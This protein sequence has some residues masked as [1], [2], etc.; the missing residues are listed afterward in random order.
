MGLASGVSFDIWTSESAVSWGN[1]SSNKADAGGHSV[2]T[3]STACDD[4]RGGG[5]L[6]VEAGVVVPLERSKSTMY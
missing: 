5:V 3:A 6:E 4:D 1:S 2:I